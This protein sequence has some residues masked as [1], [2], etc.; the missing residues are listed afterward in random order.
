MSSATLCSCGDPLG[1]HLNSLGDTSYC[2]RCNCLSWRP[3]REESNDNATL[4]AD[5][6]RAREDLATAQRDLLQMTASRNDWSTLAQR[7]EQAEGEMERERDEQRKRADSLATAIRKHRDAR[8]DDRCWLD[9]LALY[10]A[11]PEGAPD[12]ADLRLCDPLTMMSNCLRFIASRQPGG[13]PYVSPQ[14]E[15]E[16]LRAQVEQLQSRRDEWAGGPDRI[17]YDEVGGAARTGTGERDS[18]DKETR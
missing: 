12:K 14:R 7:Y 2:R 8:G 11:L 18:D 4:R 10:A 6:Q 16:S 5:L 9:D 15:I 17:G 1:A 13:E 3:V